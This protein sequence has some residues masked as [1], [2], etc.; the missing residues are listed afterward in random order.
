[1]PLALGQSPLDD[2]DCCLGLS[3]PCGEL[4]HWMAIALS[5]RLIGQVNG[6][7]LVVKQREVSGHHGRSSPSMLTDRSVSVWLSNLPCSCSC[8]CIAIGWALASGKAPVKA[9]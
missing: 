7:G 1:D 6:A 2:P 4:E 3:C 8:S 5:Q 9:C